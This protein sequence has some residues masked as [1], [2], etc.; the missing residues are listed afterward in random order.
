LIV[1]QEARVVRIM[2]E[3]KDIRL[4]VG[5]GTDY[6]S[7]FVNVD[8][9][10]ILQHIDKKVDIS[11][12]SLLDHFSPESVSYIL[13]NDIIEHHFH[14]E[15][16]R[17]LNDFY[18]LLTIG[19]CVEIRVPDAEFIIRSWRMP[20]AVKLNL[21]FGGLDIPQ[22]VDLEMD[23]SR[24]VYPQY[25]CHKYGWTMAQMK[26][27]LKAIGF[28]AIQCVRSGTNFISHATK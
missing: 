12:E 11:K 13:A 10:D 9:S 4:N 24:R 20:L 5:C 17:I 23:T 2:S 27:E 16:V 25:F 21:L 3:Y 15:A 6:R 22:G 14:W 18:R 28:K 8:G 26:A 19:G 7:G 1:F